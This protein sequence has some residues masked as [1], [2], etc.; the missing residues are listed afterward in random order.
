MERQE[1][2]ELVTRAASNS[3]EFLGRSL[4]SAKN[5]PQKQKQRIEKKI[6]E[7]VG[8]SNTICYFEVSRSPQ[9]NI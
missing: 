2:H 9:A 1:Q 8:K 6:K 5:R 7:N 4:K 3:L